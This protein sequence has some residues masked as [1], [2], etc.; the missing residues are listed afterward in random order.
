MATSGHD[1]RFRQ[2]V[3]HGASRS[4]DQLRRHLAPVALRH[5]EDTTRL[6]GQGDL[7]H[8]HCG[9]PPCL[10]LFSPMGRCQRTDGPT[11]IVLVVWARMVLIALPDV[12]IVE[13]VPQFPEALLVSLLGFAYAVA[14]VILC[15]SLFGW[16]VRRR[17][18]YAI[19]VLRHR[20]RLSEPLELLV[21]RLGDTLPD[22]PGG[23]WF[24]E[25]HPDVTLP[26][27]AARH[28]AGYHKISAHDEDALFDLSQ[29][30][31]RR[32][33]WSCGTAIAL[34]LTTGSS[35]HGGAAMPQGN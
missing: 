34:T 29:S 33:R 20:A 24:A 35:R 5:P 10:D 21:S 11:A 16:P 17:R 27:G 13:N 7:G 23:G 19:C 1:A 18:R 31:T 30:P 6:L 9:G 28:L 12:V 25:S 8:L 22:V 3:V 4:F 15:P 2:P 32:P 26:P 14:S